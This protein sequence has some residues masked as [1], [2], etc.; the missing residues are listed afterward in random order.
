MSK[1]T[2]TPGPWQIIQHTDRDDGK[3]HLAIANGKPDRCICR[4]SET[5]RVDHEDEANASL[6]S[7]A[8]DLLEAARLVLAK[9][10][11]P[12]ASVTAFDADKLRA[13]IAK[14]EPSPVAK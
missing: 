9:L 11:H 10:D 12:T 8:P 1:H 2:P 4:L 5:K 6:I 3:V 13:A 7:A 14:A